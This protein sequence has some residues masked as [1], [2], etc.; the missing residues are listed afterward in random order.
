MSQM[1]LFRRIAEKSVSFLF[2]RRHLVFGLGSVAVF[3]ACWATAIAR[4]PD[5]QSVVVG[6][7]PAVAITL[8]EPRMSLPVFAWP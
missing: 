8:V 3:V 5:A 1:R 2:L 7:Q 4:V 6:M